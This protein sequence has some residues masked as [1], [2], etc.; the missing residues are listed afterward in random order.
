M[1]RNAI[2]AY[3]RPRRLSVVTLLVFLM[4][5]GA[6]GA[7][8][9]TGVQGQSRIAEDP[10][11]PEGYIQYGKLLQS[12]GALAEAAEILETGRNKA[13]Q[14]ADLLVVLGAVYAA[15][16]LVA[17]AE[18]T[19]REALV[20]E[21]ENIA[22]RLQLGQLYFDLGWPKSGLESFRLANELAPADPLPKVRLVGGLLEAGQ[23][24]AAEDQCLQ[25]IATDADNPDLW[26]ALGQVFERQGKHREAFTTYGQV[27]SLDPESGVAY[28]RRGRLFCQFGQYGSAEDACRK[29]LELDPDNALGHAY[30]G[31]ACSYLG[32]GDQAR[33]HAQVAESAGLNMTVVW[34]KIGK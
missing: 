20:L 2:S 25:F 32:K 34:K 28:A 3:G 6:A 33:H 29:A 9:T 22:A 11:D 12:R 27:L 4:V 26:L 15:Q 30:L 19:T 18:A 16:D 5:A 24:L 7:E 21:P 23:L 31:I 17:R 1:I 10:T 14:S 13:H 8:M